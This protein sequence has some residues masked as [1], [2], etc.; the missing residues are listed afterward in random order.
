MPCKAD[1]ILPRPRAGGLVECGDE[2]VLVLGERS[3]RVA[4]PAAHARSAVEL[5]GTVG[6]PA[7]S[8]VHA[9]GPQLQPEFALIVPGRA[10]AAASGP[11][12]VVAGLER[13]FP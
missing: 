13:H 4:P 11:K 8:V 9:L 6:V 1:S 2:L 10:H 12:T 5:Q 3:S 7:H